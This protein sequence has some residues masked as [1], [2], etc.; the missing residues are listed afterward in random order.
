MSS[1]KAQCY[2]GGVEIELDTSTAPDI[3][4]YCH[5]DDCRKAHASPLYQAVYNGDKNKVK[6]LKG[7]SLIKEYRKEGA[8][9]VRAFC[10]EC[11]SR[12]YNDHDHI[13]MGVFPGMFSPALP[14]SHKPNLHF[15]VKEAIFPLDKLSDSLPRVNSVEEIQQQA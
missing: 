8:P 5:C 2:C 1:A 4:T 12:V 11:G 7:K 3:S 13:G 9:L 15:L 14:D 6:I 10:T